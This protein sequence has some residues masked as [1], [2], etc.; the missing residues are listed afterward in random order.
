MSPGLSQA[1]GAKVL[2]RFRHRP[3][4]AST[5]FQRHAGTIH[6]HRHFLNVG[7]EYAAGM[8]LGE[9]NVSTI[10]LMLAA[11]LTF[12]HRSSTLRYKDE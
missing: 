10:H 6:R 12:C 7:L 8:A 9:A 4:T 3:Y 2:A 1:F 5:D 11:H